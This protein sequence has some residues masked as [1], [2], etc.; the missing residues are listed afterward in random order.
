MGE[1]ATQ[2]ARLDLATSVS[3]AVSQGT[4]AMVRSP[5]HHRIGSELT[6][7]PACPNG[8][9]SSGPSR[10]GSS[11]RGK[12]G[13]GRG[14]KSGGGRGRKKSTSSFAAADDYMDF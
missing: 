9:G 10:R 14:S 3:S 1:A 7:V 4:I 11:S 5:L 2:V 6:P 12:R 13:R 8:G